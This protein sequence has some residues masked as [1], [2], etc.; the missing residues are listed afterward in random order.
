VERNIESLTSFRVHDSAGLGGTIPEEIYKLAELS[1][2]E[3]FNT[4]IGGTISTEIGN[5]ILL[6]QFRINDCQLY[7]TI[8]TEM[9]LL[10]RLNDIWLQGNDLTGN[11]P[12][13]VCSNAILSL[14]LDMDS[15]ELKADCLDSESTGLPAVTCATGCCTSCCDTETRLCD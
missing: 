2:F 10:V 12:E 13:Q 8:P 7:G 14:E 5:M 15:F 6:R 4:N 1:K 9:G 3:M 11:I